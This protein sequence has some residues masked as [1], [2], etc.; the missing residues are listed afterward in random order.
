MGR[1]AMTQAQEERAMPLNA[2][3]TLYELLEKYAPAWY[4][5]EHHDNAEAALRLTNTNET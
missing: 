4:T 3:K 2:L 5:R 1:M